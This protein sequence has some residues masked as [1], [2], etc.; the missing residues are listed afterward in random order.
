MT[1]SAAGDVAGLAIF[2]LELQL[3]AYTLCTMGADFGYSGGTPFD[4]E[5]AAFNALI[6]PPPPNALI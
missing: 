1:T 3:A 6:V 5:S 2:K 4:L